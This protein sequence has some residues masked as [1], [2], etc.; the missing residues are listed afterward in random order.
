MNK[1]LSTKIGT[2]I[3]EARI[4]LGYTQTDLGKKVGVATSHI[5]NFENGIKCPSLNM[6]YKLE[7][8]LGPIWNEAGT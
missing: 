5:C 8:C 7:K 2:T 6:L 1:K 3:R 4:A